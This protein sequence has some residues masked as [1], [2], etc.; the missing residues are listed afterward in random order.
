M[1][2][3]SRLCLVEDSASSWMIALLSPSFAPTR[4]GTEACRGARPTAAA[5]L[6]KGRG[7]GRRV[8]SAGPPDLCRNLDP[9]NAEEHGTGRMLGLWGEYDVQC[10]TYAGACISKRR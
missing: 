10:V 2:P 4:G 1:I 3:P 6:Y 8:S 9:D 7:T 5:Y